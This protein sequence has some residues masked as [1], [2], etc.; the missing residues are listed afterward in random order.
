MS[1]KHGNFD[2]LLASEFKDIKFG[3]AYVQTCLDEHITLQEALQETIKAMGLKEFSTKSG[4]SIQAVTDFVAGRA[5][6]STDKVIRL[7]EVVFKLKV[8]ISLEAIQPDK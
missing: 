6:W 1:Y 5:R 7:L 4:Q 2:E 3:Q 8:K